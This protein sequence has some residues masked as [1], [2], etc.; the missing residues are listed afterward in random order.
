VGRNL[1]WSGSRYIL[2][3]GRFY[4]RYGPDVRD[5]GGDVCQPDDVGQGGVSFWSDVFDG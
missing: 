2:R 1:F 3:F 4:A 5:G